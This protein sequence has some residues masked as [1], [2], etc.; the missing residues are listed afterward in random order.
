[1]TSFGR[2]CDWLVCLWNCTGYALDSENRA[3]QV[4]NV[5]CAEILEDD[6]CTKLAAIIY[7]WVPNWHIRISAGSRKA[8]DLYGLRNR[9]PVRSG[10]SDRPVS[11]QRLRGDITRPSS[12]RPDTKSLARQ[13][14]EIQEGRKR[15]RKGFI[16]LTVRQ[17]RITLFTPVRIVL[18]C[19]W[20]PL[21]LLEYVA[22]LF[23]YPF[24]EH[25]SLPTQPDSPPRTSKREQL[26]NFFTAPLVFLDPDLSQYRTRRERGEHDHR[27]L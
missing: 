5:L 12:P 27:S 14:I 2:K 16:P 13:L 10:G 3:S 20:I 9:R 17:V 1:M 18:L 8:A 24:M 4:E 21:L 23:C 6:T 11:Q 7:R 15:S 25:S 26:K 22:L 19:V